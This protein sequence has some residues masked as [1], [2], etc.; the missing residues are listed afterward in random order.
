MTESTQRLRKDKE[1]PMNA[2]TTPTGHPGYAPTLYNEDL[3]PTPVSQR[4]WGTW[5]YTAL[6][7]GMVSS[8]FAF[9]F[10]G[11]FIALGMSA[12]QA[13]MVVLIGAVVQTLLMSLTGRVGA[14]HGLPFAVW[15]RTAFGQKGANLP[16]VLRGLIAVG[17]FGVQSYLGST[18]V[19]LMI[20]TVIPPF[21]DLTQPVILGAP[22]NLL[23]SMVLFW[24]ASFLCLRDGIESIRRL[25]QWAG[26]LVFIALIP[27]FIWAVVSA[28]GFG[29]IF[30][31]PSRFE[32]MGAFLLMGLLPGVAL[33]ISG[34]WATMVLN[35]PDL[36]RFAQSNRKQFMGT[37]LGLPLGSLVF[38]GMS[39][40]I[41][42]GTQVVTGKTLWN[43]ADILAEINNPIMSFVGAG[44]IAIA[45]MSTNVAANLVS[46]AYDFTNA[47]PKIFTFKRAGAFAIIA[48]FAYMPWLIM[49]SPAFTTIMNYIGAIAG[50]A[51]GILLADYY[52]IRRQRIDI[53]ALYTPGQR[54]HAYNWWNIGAL[55]I[56]TTFIIV[57]Q[58]I[59]GLGFFYAYA[60]LLG[61]L[62]G[63]ALCLAF[64]PLARR[65]GLADMYEPVGDLGI[66][67]VDAASVSDA[68]DAIETDAASE[69]DARLAAERTPVSNSADR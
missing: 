42:S 68:A 58:M 1:V 30:S 16:A 17:W 38:Y 56:A 57:S 47:L 60:P 55:V 44:V 23:I 61:I 48:G 54:Y 27:P 45:T 28:G 29:P 59:P 6:W 67:Q 15:A 63:M 37:L 18:A 7:L 43:P 64:A 4:T 50:P 26:P 33:F 22:L 32:S 25:Q 53:D 35:Y 49:D 69:I 20:S 3:A 52:L 31:G 34:S 5:S 2:G 36:T 40:V 62:L 14:K 21:K 13:L 41:V 10:L 51:T 8:A 19:N 12:A 11:T 9:A 24:G 66:E 39:A 65:N 46:P